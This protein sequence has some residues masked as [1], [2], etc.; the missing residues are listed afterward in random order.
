MGDTILLE[1]SDGLARLTLNR[2]RSLN[3]VNSA[4]AARWR[5]LAL[6]VTS[7]DSI[8][9]VLIEATGPAFCAGGD[10]LEMA[11]GE[12]GGAGLTAL[13]GVIGDG[14]TAF[15]EGRVPIVA[16]VEGPVVGGG[17]GLMLVADYIVASDAATFASRYADVGLTP[18][19]GVTTFLPRAVGERRALQLLLSD[20]VLDAGTALEWGLVSEVTTPDAAPVR[21]EQVA[22]SWLG[23]A[24]FGQARRLVRAASDRPLTA[25]LA[26]EAATIGARLDTD[27]ARQRIAAFVARRAP[28]PGSA[29]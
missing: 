27:Q 2:P 23:N 3:A 1:I 21:A 24:A 7:D 8:G 9:A 26:D 28:R 13:A 29:R 4:M 17:L 5:E 15:A 22:R 18:D 12:S 16:C 6:Q 11:T 25:N 19:L 14:I 20:L 10:V